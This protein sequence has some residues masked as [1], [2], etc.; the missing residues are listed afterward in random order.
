[1]QD[2]AHDLSVSSPDESN[3]NKRGISNKPTLLVIED[4]QLVEIEKQM[5]HQE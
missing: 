3:D 1:M 5:K 4:E 2:Q